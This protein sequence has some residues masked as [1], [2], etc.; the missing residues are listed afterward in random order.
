LIELLSRLGVQR[1]AIGVVGLVAVGLAGCTED[2]TTPGSCPQTC[3]GGTIV[4]RDTVIDAVFAGDSTYLGYVFPGEG[5]GLLTSTTGSTNQYLTAMR[6]GILPDSVRI[7]DS[8]Y[9]YTIDSVAITLGVLARD[10]VATGLWL[11]LF[12]APATLDSGVT[13][14]DVSGYMTPGTFLD[15]LA[16]NDTLSSGNVRAVFEGADLLKLAIPPT[17][18]GVLAIAIGLTADSVTGVELG[19]LTAATF[20]PTITWYISVPEVDSTKQPAN[21][22][23][24]PTFATYVQE[25]PPALD[26]DQLMVGGAPSAR[27]IVRFSVPDSVLIGAEILRAELMLTP[28]QPITGVPNIGTTITARGVLSDQGGKSPLVPLIANSSLVTI[29]SADTV[30]VEVVDIVRTWQLVTNPPAQAFFI[31]LQ[32]ESSSFTIPIFASTRSAAGAPRLRVTYV[33]SL[34]FEEP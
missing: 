34:D 20:L 15:S 18:S 29:G 3:P 1:L 26:P 17:D 31:S 16:I 2:F 12:R 13:F 4:I 14:T 24:V 30:F 28:V 6:F 8:L 22:R 33:A 23:R 11:Q 19:N 9:T 25:N 27:F 7:D 21:I 5:T 10:S 32:P